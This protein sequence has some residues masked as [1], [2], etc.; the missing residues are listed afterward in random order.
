MRSTSVSCE[1]E[2]DEPRKGDLTPINLA[3]IVAEVDA[4]EHHLAGAARQGGTHLRENVLNLDG[5]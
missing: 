3:A 2:L 4:R 1:D 5:A